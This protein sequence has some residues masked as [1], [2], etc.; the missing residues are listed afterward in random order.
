MISENLNKLAHAREQYM[1]LS[2]QNDERKEFHV[3][4]PSKVFKHY[5]ST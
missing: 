1:N 2:F 5:R 4:L 3:R